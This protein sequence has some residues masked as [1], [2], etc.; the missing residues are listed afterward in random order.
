MFLAIVD[1][2]R[3]DVDCGCLKDCDEIKY[4]LQASSSMFYFQKSRV[5]WTLVQS[6]VIY[7]RELIHGMTEALILTGGSLSL[8]IGMSVLTL[9]EVV[10]FAYLFFK[11]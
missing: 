9:I 1:S 6:K 3:A 2:L 7:R 4:S 10:F 8:F 5:S 11:K